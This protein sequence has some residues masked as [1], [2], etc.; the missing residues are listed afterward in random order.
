VLCTLNFTIQ[1]LLLLPELTDN[2]IT[3]TDGDPVSRP[4]SSKVMVFVNKQLINYITFSKVTP[5]I[6]VNGLT[7]SWT[8]VRTANNFS[9]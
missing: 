9:Y 1:K 2:S 4:Y 3:D 7:A 6:K 5:R 8:H